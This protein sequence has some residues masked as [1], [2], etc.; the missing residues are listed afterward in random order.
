MEKNVQRARVRIPFFHNG[1]MFIFLLSCLYA[2][3]SNRLN[4]LYLL[5]HPVRLQNEFVSTMIHDSNERTCCAIKVISDMEGFKYTSNN[6]VVKVDD[7]PGQD[8]V[9]VSPDEMVLEIFHTG[10]EPFKVIF[11]EAG[12]TPAERVVWS[13]RIAGEK[14]AAVIPIVILSTP[15]EADI[16]IDGVNRGKAENHQ[17]GIG[18]HELRLVKAGYQTL[19]ETIQVDEKTTL[20]RRTLKKQEEVNIRIESDPE[21]AL[22]YI[23]GVRIGEAP[24]AAFFSAGRYPIRIEKEW[25]VTREDYIDIQPPRVKQLYK[26]EPNF[27][28]LQVSSA[29]QS[30]LQV[31][32]DGIDQN[33]RTPATLKP[34]KPALYAVKAKSADYETD[35]QK[36]QLARG[37]SK[38][39]RLNSVAGF[40]TLTIRTVSGAKVTL[41]GK[42]ITQLENIRLTPSVVLVRAELAKAEPV[43]EHVVLR[44]GDNRIIQLEPL[45]PRGAILVAAVP[46]Q[47][48]IELKGDAGESYNGIGDKVFD[49][50]P[51]GRYVLRLT[52]A[53]YSD[54]QESI[55]L[56]TGER[57]SKNI[58]LVKQAI[59]SQQI[60]QRQSQLGDETW[61]DP[62]TGIEFVLIKGGTFQMGDLF[63]EGDS[64]EKPVHTVTV[65][66]FYLAKTEVSVGQYKI[67]NRKLI[68]M[69]SSDWQDKLPMVNVSWQAAV[70]FCNWMGCRLPT[71]AEW[72]YAAREGGR[73]VRFGN[74]KDIADPVEMNYDASP[75]NVDTYA[76]AGIYRRTTLPVG[77]FAANSLG[78][79]DMSGNVWEWCQDW[80]KFDFYR[81][82]SSSTN[83]V[84]PANGEER[85]LRGGC[86]GGYP[87]DCRASNRYKSRPSDNLF[88]IGFRVARSVH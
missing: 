33:V 52:C 62:K 42:T 65:S 63:D 27:C 83:P 10:Y 24:V 58:K 37:E 71:E 48:R 38:A 66:D 22:V 9:Y 56:T 69:P 12:I 68:D 41:D 61:R 46:E 84:G 16:F 1:W 35:E 8:M 88:F 32:L 76:R 57:V 14:S 73:K 34:L 29:P 85:V 17:V 81:R 87:K 72:E 15:T 60:M 19:T 47:A 80:Y 49:E 78:L 6:G 67:Y 7:L 30:G 82:R 20:F 21:G 77:S 5:D 3:E 54:Y 45:V 50:I 74:G 2:Q 28:E 70:D 11:S 75:G 40:A 13:I 51:I 25:Y 59:A 86:W 39:V 36:V 18:R 31:Y 79:Y 43:E 26:L 53:G 55:T 44:K 4:R 23:D 64:D